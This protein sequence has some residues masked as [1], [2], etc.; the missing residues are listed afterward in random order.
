MATWH[1]TARTSIGAVVLAAA[2]ATPFVLHDRAGSA[3]ETAPHAPA[4]VGALS[5][6]VDGDGT[7]DTVTLDR[8]D[9][10]RVRLGAG[11][12]VEHLLQ[13]RPRL[14]GLVDVGH[15]HLAIAV[16]RWAA[17]R[18]RAWTAWEVRRNRIAP[19]PV[20]D[21]QVIGSEPGSSAVWV[22]GHRLYDGSLDPLQHGATQVVVASRTW[23]LRGGRLTSTAAGLRCWDRSSNATPARCAPDQ[24]WSYDVGPHG[25]LPALLPTV[26]PAWADRSSTTFSGGVWKVRNL[27]P[28]VDPEAAPY[29]VTHTQ[30][31]V[32]HATPVPVGWAPVLFGPPVRLADGA[33]A[34][35]LSQEGGDSDT[36]R[37]Y[38]DR[39]GR[40][41]PLPLQGPVPL[42]GGFREVHGVDR[43]YLSWLTREGR[44]YTRVG[45]PTPGRF[46]VWAWM[47]TGG[48][49][50]AP[51]TL[52]ARDL[53]TVCI[54]ETLGT[55]GTCAA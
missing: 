41:Q 26:R 5:G 35:L 15:G 45:S 54:D 38:V 27:D 7:P 51:P 2:C 16:S 23:T 28:D 8:H 17:G 33:P 42:G 12:T 10:L 30:G 4:A 9:R 25:E 6:D 53:G 40:V 18:S 19:L 20:R 43:A 24:D 48:D 46:H 36:W 37:V 31:G 39:G 55:Y 32:V 29:D 14:E 47:P 3:S 34:V 52:V 11:G 1:P 13:D 21:R 22:A 49:A 50:T 44:L